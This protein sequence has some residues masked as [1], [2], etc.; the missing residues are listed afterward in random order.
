MNF[1]I[2]IYLIFFSILSTSALY[3]QTKPKLVIGIT[4]D[5]MKQEYLY[6]FWDRYGDDGF[7]KLINNGHLYVDAHYSYRPTY[8]AP[9]HASIYTGTTPAVHGIVG[10]SWYDKETES[11]VYCVRDD[12]VSTIGSGSQAGEMSPRRMIS[13]TISDE[14][15][16]S[17]GMKGKSIGISI[18]DRGAILPAGHAADAAY[19][20]DASIGGWV[21]SS[22]YMDE[23]PLW[24]Q[25]HNQEGL[26]DMYIKQ[27]WE[28]LYPIETYTKSLA[29]NNPFEQ[30]F[31]PED[32]PTFPHKLSEI[33][34]KIGYSV[35]PRTP[36]GNS[37]V[38]KMVETT[39]MAEDLG[40]DEFTDILA[41]SFSSTDYVG[42][43]FGP[44]SIEIEDTYLRLDIEIATLINF[45][46][47]QVGR[48]NYVLFLTADHG[49][50]ETPLY[51]Q[52]YNIPAGYF[53]IEKYKNGIKNHLD[54]LFGEGPWIKNMSNDQ[55]FLNH[56]YLDDKG[57][58]EHD[59]SEALINY[60]MRFEGISN[61]ITHENLLNG[62]HEHL[63]SLHLAQR[64]YNQ[65]RSGDIFII[66]EPGWM[67]YIRQGTTHGSSYS[68]DT[69][70]PLIWYGASIQSGK[71][72]RRANIID[73]APT[74]S[75]I[76]EVTLPNGSAGRILTE[77]IK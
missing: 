30:V 48:D 32:T 33:F 61:V 57:A 35:I 69:H 4:V 8:T 43:Q 3:S 51:L 54:S 64:G 68:Y 2:S 12:N 66:M 5:Q 55:I 72:Y 15:K 47:N 63:P 9:G 6:R 22:Y 75:A 60:S 70:V 56:K 50:A 71:S 67:T 28:T 65:R 38:Q 44:R 39:I 27:D 77:V 18:K 76:L 45:L 41:V 40:G 20:F 37:F 17:T 46:D 52:N 73:I 23:L 10:N 59:I 49:A 62:S 24:L 36:F 14:I 16:L 21:T 26:A 25:D 7:K 34:E 29:D 58:S 19:W 74:L 13:S 31:K 11:T 1:K 42:H 53:N